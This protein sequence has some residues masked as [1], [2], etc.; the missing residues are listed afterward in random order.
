MLLGTRH[1][2]SAAQALSRGAKLF[3]AAGRQ[4]EMSQSRYHV[5][6]SEDIG[7]VVRRLRCE[8]DVWAHRFLGLLRHHY[9]AATHTRQHVNVYVVR[10]T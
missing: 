7:I 8:T 9:V 10:P 3:L 2:R 4:G 5:A 1:V 6:D